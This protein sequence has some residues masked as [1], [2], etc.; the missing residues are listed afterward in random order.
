M[1]RLMIWIKRINRTK[2]PQMQG[3]LKSLV[4]D[5]L[6]RGDGHLD[7]A[8]GKLPL[9]PVEPLDNEW[10][11]AWEEDATLEVRT[12]L[13]TRTLHISANR[14]SVGAMQS[15]RKIAAGGIVSF[16]AKGSKSTRTGIVIKRRRL[17]TALKNFIVR[18]F[19]SRFSVLI[20]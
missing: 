20:I 19:I 12:R 5:Q 15:A 13:G 11:T 1:S 7:G 10:R 17:S 3:T 8:K 9:G 16:G 18:K 14:A 2:T 4:K 6:R